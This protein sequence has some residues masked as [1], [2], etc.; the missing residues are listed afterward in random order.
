ALTFYY[1]RDVQRRMIREE[2]DEGPDDEE[3]GRRRILVAVGNSELARELTQ[4]ATVVAGHGEDGQ[5]A[6][7]EEQAGAEVTLL[8]VVQLSGTEVSHA[9]TVQESMLEDAVERIRPLRELVEEA[10]FDANPV[11]IA[12]GHVGE[13]IARV[14]NELDVDLVLMGFHEP[15]FGQR[16]LGGVV[17]EVLR[18][19][20][21]DVAVLVDPEGPRQLGLRDDARVLVPYG[22]NFHE[23]VGLDLA[24]RLA[25]STGAGLTLLASEDGEAEE[26]AT[27]AE[28]GTDFPME[29]VRVEGDVTEE[30]FRR[31]QDFDLLV[32]GVGER[33]MTEQ[34]TL[35]SV[36]EEVMEKAGKPY[37][38]VRRSGGRRDSLRRRWAQVKRA[39]AVIADVYRSDGDDTAG[40]A[41][42]DTRE[43]LGDG[44]ADGDGGNGK[45]GGDRN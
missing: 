34:E 30:L 3:E 43:R 26:K 29:R 36:R 5:E 22:G 33:W 11:A 4:V 7:E 8:R 10:G 20:R 16:L 38:L 28:E 40:E 27:E 44:T 37:L 1:P 12:G 6:E 19:A 14:A 42:E 35:A 17:G 21:A 41:G 23:Q 25:R 13:T 31:A 24:L 2:T 39:P 9:P 45:G 32:L 15:L 18:D